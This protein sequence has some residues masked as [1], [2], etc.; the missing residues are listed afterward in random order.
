MRKLTIMAYKVYESLS[1]KFDWKPDKLMDVKEQ[2]AFGLA[3][4]DG[5]KIKA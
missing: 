3:Q 2:M 4:I 5:A 1:H